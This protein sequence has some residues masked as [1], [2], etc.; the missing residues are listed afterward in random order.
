MRRTTALSASSSPEGGAVAV[1]GRAMSTTSASG[2]GPP[3]RRTAARSTRFDLLRR[4]A[5]PSFLPATKA[6]RPSR[7]R[8]CG[9]VRVSAIT[10]GWETRTP[11]RNTSSIS[12]F[13]RIVR[14]T[15]R[16][17]H[18]CSTSGRQYLAALTAA[19]RKY[20]A[21]CTCRHARAKP[22]R[23]ATLAGVWLVGPLHDS[24]L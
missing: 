5:L 2:H 7:P 23:L 4:T 20:A 22:V 1:E 16:P 8:P 6:T 17:A 19:T 11:V 18:G 14:I 15:S 21:P 12:R 10:K 24:L 3:D 9:V 13:D